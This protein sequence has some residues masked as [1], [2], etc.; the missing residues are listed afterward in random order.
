MNPSKCF[1]ATLILLYSNIF[2]FQAISQVLRPAFLNKKV[3]CVKVD[4]NY[5]NGDWAPL[6]KQ[7]ENKRIILL[8]EPNHGAAEI[9]LSRND[10]I[11]SLHA[12][13]GFN[14]ILFESGIG[15]LISI[16]QQQ[17]NLT[18]EEMTLGFFGGWRNREFADLMRYVKANNISVSGFDVQRTGRSFEALMLTELERLNLDAEPYLGLEKRF[19]EE[20][21]K[22]NDRSV[23]MKTVQSSTP[24]LMEDYHTLQLAMESV[25]SNT[26][27]ETALFV[28]RALQNRIAYL[29]YF[30][31]FKEN[32]DWRQRWSAR[33][34]MMYSNI[35]WLLNKVY[36][37]QK[38]VIV[39]HNFHI[40]KYNE[41]EEVMG[42]MLYKDYGPDMYAI[43][44]FAG[45]GSYANNRGT[46]EDLQPVSTEGFD[47]KR[48][49][50]RLNCKSGFLAIPE[51][52]DK[53]LDW[54]Y[55][56]IIVNDTFIDLNS[57]NEMELSK[58]FDGLIFIDKISPPVKN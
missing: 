16:N 48:I 23:A 38:V 6:L 1:G 15:E 5:Q 43:G 26:F 3:Q 24:K 41:K 55:R 20:K 34:Y 58:H 29:K 2:S 18:P 42:A 49:I 47:I 44:V 9:F 46:K 28:Q 54:L 21:K 7:V 17:K 33:D 56:K 52:E 51:K 19:S 14:V 13:L 35:D 11:K 36:K 4:S 30:L 22:L 45:K 25:D 50:N 8:G 37:D 27:N 31:D 10:L 57:S 40:S 32:R 12:A 53:R 39:A